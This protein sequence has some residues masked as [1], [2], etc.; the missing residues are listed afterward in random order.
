MASSSKASAKRVSKPS[1]KLAGFQ[2]ITKIKKECAEKV[3]KIVKDVR[4]EAPSEFDRYMTEHS[5]ESEEEFAQL[6]SEEECEGEETKKKKRS[7]KRRTAAFGKK[8][9]HNFVPFLIFLLHFSLKFKTSWGRERPV[10]LRQ[11]F[12]WLQGH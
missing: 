9:F 1:S 4:D 11:N 12:S 5:E 8:S 2:L 10:P 3:N 7:P 6:L